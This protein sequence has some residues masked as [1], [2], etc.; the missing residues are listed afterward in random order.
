MTLVRA[1]IGALAPTP[2]TTEGAVMLGLVLLAA[3]FA[4]AGMP[5]L[6]LIIPGAVLVVLGGLPALRRP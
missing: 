6:A 2:G 3:G 1:V 5:Q 4:V